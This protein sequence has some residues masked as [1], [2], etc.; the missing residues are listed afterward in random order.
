MASTSYPDSQDAGWGGALAAQS[1]PS[2]QPEVSS[3]GDLLWWPLAL[4][5]TLKSDKPLGV[6]LGDRRIVLWRDALGEP[7]AMIDQCPHRRV[8]LSLG[9]VTSDGLLQ[10]GYHGW[11]FEGKTGRV[12]RIP[13]MLEKQRFPPIYRSQSYGVCETGGFIRVCLNK[14]APPPQ[15]EAEHLALYG[16]T[17]VALGHA[18]YVAMLFDNPSLLIDIPGVEIT[19]YFDSELTLADGVVQLDRHCVRRWHLRHS[20]LRSHFPFR[21]RVQT[22]LATGETK[23]RL[24]NESLRELSRIDLAPTPGGRGTTTVNWRAKAGA[25]SLAGLRRPTPAIR[26]RMALDVASIAATAPT[27]SVQFETKVQSAP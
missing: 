9:R 10:C 5:E 4:S 2:E 3:D 26:V 17:P 21:L 16:T 19:E 8:P 25:P 12:S 7:R 14:D 18:H 20:R 22:V 6:S 23:I 24:L 1:D 27:V 15:P 11:C 13:N